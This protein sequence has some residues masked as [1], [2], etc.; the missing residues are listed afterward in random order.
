VSKFAKALS[1]A[2]NA[3]TDFALIELIADA[4]GECR[5]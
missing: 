2:L 1:T 3:N 4:L 5:I